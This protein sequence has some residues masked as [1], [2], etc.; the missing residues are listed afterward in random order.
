[1]KFLRSLLLWRRAAAVEPRGG[2]LALAG[3]G[4]ASAGAASAPRGPLAHYDSALAGVVL[5]LV[6]FGTVMVYSASVSLADSPRYNVTP[7][8]FLLRHVIALGIAFCAAAVAFAIPLSAWQKLAPLAF[9]AVLLL[10][11]VV[12]V[13][14]VGKGALGAK[15]WIPLGLL[16]LQ[17]SELMKVACVLYAANFTVRKQ[18][19]MHEFR[20]GFLPMATVMAIVGVLLLLQPDLGA[21]GVIVAISMGILFLGGVNARIF[22]AITVAL[23]TAF[24]AVIWLSPWRRER[25]FAYLDPWSAENALGKGYQLSHSLIAFGRGEWFGVGLGA[26]VEKLHYLPEAHTDFILAVIGEELGLVA[27]LAVIFAFY[28]LVKRAFEI[29][30]QAIALDR[31]FAGLVA[32]G[33]GLW[34]GVQAFIN[35]GVA[36]G[37]LPTKGLTLPL[38]SYGGSALLST[39]T[40]LGILLRVDYENRKLMRG[41]RA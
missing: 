35:I 8:H 30:R 5:A 15:R 9:V 27:V 33:I 20:K 7:T 37:L 6:V 28:W 32:Q 11:V 26:S 19:Y 31:T 25:I 14:G 1:M 10:L 23:A 38:M 29:G 4:S 17:P 16:N 2:V 13:P 40:A 22:A 24:A 41:G 12:L 34:L 18:D 21:F 36:T 39:L 3:F